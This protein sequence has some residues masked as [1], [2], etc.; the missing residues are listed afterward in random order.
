MRNSFFFHHGW[1]FRLANVFLMEQ[2]L[3]ACRDGRG[4]LPTD[5]SLWETSRACS[6]G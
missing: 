1:R 6:N 3:D 4:N 5:P 2:A